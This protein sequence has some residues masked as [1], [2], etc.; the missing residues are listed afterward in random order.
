MGATDRERD[1]TASNRTEHPARPHTVGCTC[2]TI[3][4]TPSR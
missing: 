1:G 2:V 4:A 3:L